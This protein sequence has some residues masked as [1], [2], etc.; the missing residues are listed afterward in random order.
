[1]HETDDDVAALQDL[2]DR[3]RAGSGEHLRQAFGP[4]LSAAEL[5]AALSGI[6]EMHLAVVTSA[7]APLVAPV[8]GFLL[9][10]RVC[11]GLPPASVR[12]GLV[13]RDPRV[14]ASFIGERCSFIVHGS[15][16]EVDDDL[17]D[18]TA[19]ELYVAQ[20]GDWFR[21]HMAE[22]QRKNGRGFAGVIEPRVLFAKGA[23]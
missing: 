5:V 23:S 18:S 4:P 16:V 11:V 13:R 10:G 15:V 3:S 8:D 7:G 22:Q 21:D 20:Y 14:S 9:R 6:F 19:T 12:T 2:L 1:V 17:F